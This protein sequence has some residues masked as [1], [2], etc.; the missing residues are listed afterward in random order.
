MKL[1]ELRPAKL[2][3][4]CS[5]PS[6]C[7]Y[8]YRLVSLKQLQWC[9]ADATVGDITTAGDGERRGHLLPARRGHPGPAQRV[10]RGERRAVAQGRC[11]HRK[12]VILRKVEIDN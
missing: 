6:G 8:S 9:E 3:Q 5:H 1:G 11:R 12:Q 4:T 2:P 7:Q 10:R